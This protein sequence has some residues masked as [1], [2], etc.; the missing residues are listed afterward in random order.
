MTIAIIGAGPAGLMA[1]ETLSA[2]GHGVT[3][4]ER[5]PTPGRRFLMAGVG[6]LN[7]THSEE[8][9]RFIGRYRDGLALLRPALDALPPEALR[10]WADGLGGDTFIG[11]SGRVFP[12]AMKASPLLRAWL[13]RLEGQGVRFALRH[14][15]TG[16]Q[17]DALAFDTPDGP[18][19]VTPD[20]T[21][22]AL[23]GASWPKLGADGSWVAPFEVQSVSVAPLR[24]SNAGLLIDWSDHMIER[25]AGAPLKPITLDFAGE[26]IQG[27]LVLTRT[28]LEGGAAYAVSSLIRERML[29]VGKVIVPLDLKPGLTR[30]AL[31]ARLATARKGDS[32]SNIL[33]KQV[34]LSPAAIALLNE[35]RKLPREPD[36]LA[37]RIKCRPLIIHGLSGL[38]RAISTAGGVA[39]EALDRAFMLRARPGSF[40]AGEMLDWEAPTGGYL[41]QAS[42]ATGAWA[43][44]GVM[45]WLAAGNVTTR[46]ASPPNL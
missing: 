29:T 39:A 15:W 10:G 44:R 38:D 20:A 5:M 12:K 42:F 26:A 22:F 31:A 43:A 17:G 24:P 30:D 19:T 14:D 6:G 35:D 40:V 21:V 34:R 13:G 8:F 7:L 46:S 18:L 23:G 25:H 2:A 1:A 3:V 11:S 36:A 37:K 32:L 28:G 16:W 41:L 33:R 4:Y 27:E 45:D 9:E